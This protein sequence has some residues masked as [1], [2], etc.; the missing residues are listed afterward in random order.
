MMSAELYQ[1]VFLWSV[2]A[3]CFWMGFNRVSSPD[4]HIQEEGSHFLFPFILSLFLAFWIGFRPVSYVFGDTANYA[5]E[6]SLKEVQ[7]VTMNWHSEWIW[8]WLMTGCKAAG[9]PVQVFFA[10][11]GFGYVMSACWAV[12]R[13]MPADPML[14]LAF[15]LASLMFFSYATNGL[16]NG[17]ACHIVLLAYSFLLDSKWV[18]GAAFC[19]LALGIHRSTLLPIA[20]I[21]TGIFLLRNVR[22]AIAFWILS[23]FISL[24]AG[25]PVSN[26]FASLGFDDR[27]TQYTQTLDDFS[28]FSHAGFRWDFLLYSSFPVILAWYICVQKGISDNWYNALVVAYCF[29]NAFWIMVIRSAFSNRFAYLSWFIYPVVVAYPLIC[30]PV[31][32]DQD[33]KTGWILLGYCTFTAFMWFVVW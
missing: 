13:L 31:W 27:M 9:L 26:F 1:P 15:L 33:R 2:I 5:L 22:Y 30:L 21:L 20:G 18:P 7:D 16:R 17:L 12:K 6:Y 28:A 14:G 32:E 3:I 11:I 4:N 23:I 29:C 24:V 19:L 10:I 8:Q 25:G